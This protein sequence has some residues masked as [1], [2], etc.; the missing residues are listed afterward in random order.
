MDSVICL[1]IVIIVIIV[2]GPVILTEA[3]MLQSMV[4]MAN[5]VHGPRALRPVEEGSS[6]AV[7]SAMT[8]HQTQMVCHVS[9]HPAILKA[10]T[11]TYVQVG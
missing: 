9:D 7:V 11:W 6:L 4:P 10:V 5:G 1:W 8:H 3:G 2:N